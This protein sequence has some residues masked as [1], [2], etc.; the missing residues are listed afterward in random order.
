MLVWADDSMESYVSQIM[1]ATHSLTEIGFAV[2]DDW[3]A[4]F[5]LTGLT[6][7]KRYATNH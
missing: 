3:F 1:T 2:P 7:Q 4:I 5:L 6:C